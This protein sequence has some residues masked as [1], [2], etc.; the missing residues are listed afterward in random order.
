MTLN[1]LETSQSFAPTPVIPDDSLGAVGLIGLFERGPMNTPVR[2]NSG[3]REII[4]GNQVPSGSFGYYNLK[5]VFE[6]YAAAIVDVVRVSGAG[7]E[8][9]DSTY[10][11]KYAAPIVGNHVAE[12][13][14][15][16]AVTIDLPFQGGQNE[17]P[18]YEI[19]TQP[20]AAVG[21]L[22]TPSRKSDGSGWMEVVFTPD[23]AAVDGDTG[24][25]TYMVNDGVNDSVV[26][27][28]AIEIHIAADADAHAWAG[29]RTC[30]VGDTIN[31]TVEG[32]DYT[33]GSGIGAPTVVAT[34][35]TRGNL[36]Q[37]G[38]TMD[39]TYEVPAGQSAGEDSFTFTVQDGSAAES[40]AATFTLNVI[41]PMN[42]FTIQA[43]YEGVADPGLWAQNNLSYAIEH[44]AGSETLFN[45]F[46]YLNGAVV[47]NHR[48]LTAGTLIDRMNSSYYA[49]IVSDVGL[50]L[51]ESYTPARP[52]ETPVDGEDNFVPIPLGVTNAQVSAFTAGAEG[53]AAVEA[54]FMGTSLNGQGVYAFEAEGKRYALIGCPE[55][56]AMASTF[57]ASLKAFCQDKKMGRAVTINGVDAEF[58]GTSLANIQGLQETSR[59]YASNF[60]WA[61]GRVIGG[62]AF[63]IPLMG[64]I[65]GMT[66]RSWANRGHWKSAAGMVDG[67]LR[68]VTSLSTVPRDI[69]EETTYRDAGLNVVKMDSSNSYAYVAT[70]R[71][72]SLDEKFKHGSRRD[73]LTWVVPKLD[74][75]LGPVLEEPNV[76]AQTTAI[77]EDKLLPFFRNIE[78]QAQS[79]SQCFKHNS[80]DTDINIEF[81]AV[82]DSQTDVK[83]EMDLADPLNDMVVYLS[84]AESS[85]E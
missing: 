17:D 78:N 84:Q 14:E 41:D 49:R 54:D 73:F 2:T 77:R 18:S 42:H 39:F 47:G 75:L 9:A 64:A 30:A 32:V 20:S 16:E 50:V 37:D 44:V 28:V 40:A 43:A 26:A 52:D 66:V 7:Y 12:A 61:W 10:A 81:V 65:M 69:G 23:A 8:E 24:S 1:F 36:V 67:V 34:G 53:A 38:V 11:S 35:C 63:S 22:G 79:K 68:F 33:V 70:C 27:T 19:L 56:P 46:L 82:T 85:G 57:A 48:S 21:V 25:F 71:T 76:L 60:G 74:A 15:G 4:F 5:G 3:N 51:T 83:L 62:P 55:T 72:L 13:R 59:T 80:V 45:L 6:N 29:E 58:A 31:I